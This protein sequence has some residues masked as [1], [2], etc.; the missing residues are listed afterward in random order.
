MQLIT[1]SN[2][3]IFIRDDLKAGSRNFALLFFFFVKFKHIYF[4]S[5][6]CFFSYSHYINHDK[7]LQEVLI[8]K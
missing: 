4:I 1:E 5:F 2:N 7:T 6:I 8:K 3:F